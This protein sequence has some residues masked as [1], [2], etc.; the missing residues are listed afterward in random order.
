MGT[1]ASHAARSVAACILATSLTAAVQPSASGS[2]STRSVDAIVQGRSTAAVEQAVARVGGEIS[3][4]L[5]IVSGAAVRVA[6]RALTRLARMPGILHVTPNAA[7]DFNQADYSL[8]AQRVPGNVGSDRLWAEGITGR[9]VTVALLDTGVHADH[10]DLAGRV[11]H[12]EDLSHESGTEAHCE[13]TFGHGT[14]MAGLIAG[15]GTSSD[16][17]FMGTAPEAKLVAIKVAGFDGATDVSNVLAGIQ[18][19][20]AHRSKYGIRVMNLSLGTDSPQTHLLSPLNYAVQKAWKSGI[21]VVVS[22]GNN[23]PN[24]RTV[25]KPADDPYVITVGASNDE[26]TAPTTDDRVPA[27]SSRGPTKANGLSKP[28][29]VAPGTHTISLRSPG[30]AID[31]AFGATAT[32]DNDY[33]RG[34]G[35]SMAAATVTGVV[36]QMLQ[37]SPTAVPDIVKNRIMSTATRIADTDRYAVGRGLVDAYAAAK[38][39]STTRANQG[40]LLGLGTGLGRIGSDRGSL[41]IEVFTPAGEAQLQG[42]Y[43]SQYDEQR[44]TLSDPLGLL[45]WSSVTYSS[46]GWDPLTWATTSWLDGA[47]AGAKWKGAKWKETVWDG[48][49]WK[50]T[51]WANSDW[52]GAKWKGSEWDGAKWKSTTWLSS[53]YAAS[54]E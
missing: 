20:V 37:A 29:I 43:T 17:R 22:A 3:T 12:C 5:P 2:G 8:E 38:S 45:P 36:A 32:V 16:G 21:A 9:G 53:W 6:A 13:D 44:I 26:L 46:A 15:D 54:W 51:E 27:F 52:L 23:G 24:L 14:F 30:S 31:Q 1:L 42:E 39:K 41:T 28:D 35:T 49:K 19:A 33:F 34:T 10:P 7:I 40:L 18:W 47:W 25:L 11:I 4:R 50:G 48:A